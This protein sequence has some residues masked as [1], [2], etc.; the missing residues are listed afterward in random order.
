LF[1]FDVV[2]V[3]NDEYLNCPCDLPWKW[4]DANCIIW[5]KKYKK[6][7]TTCDFSII[8]IFIQQYLM[9]NVKKT[10]DNY[11]GLCDLG[12]WNLKQKNGT[13]KEWSCIAIGQK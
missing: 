3:D 4:L 6:N 9:V 10:N 2:F 1:W 5:L 13:F 11:I 12:W 7:L 8:L